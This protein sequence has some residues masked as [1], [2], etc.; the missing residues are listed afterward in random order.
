MV[1]GGV[2]VVLLLTGAVVLLFV[3]GLVTGA[4]RVPFV[5]VY[6]PQYWVKPRAHALSAPFPEDICQRSPA[7][8]RNDWTHFV[9]WRWCC[10]W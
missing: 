3:G 5:G 2:V 6:K 9:R 8:M 7:Q 1:C 4:E 10:R